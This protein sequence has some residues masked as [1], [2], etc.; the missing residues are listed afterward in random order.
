MPFSSNSAVRLSA[1]LLVPSQ[2]TMTAATERTGEPQ[3]AEL[4]SQESGVTGE[5][6]LKVLRS[7]FCFPFFLLLKIL[8]PQ[9]EP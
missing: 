1:S 6:E 5:Y 2:A 4:L 9:T 3:L 7:D 8:F